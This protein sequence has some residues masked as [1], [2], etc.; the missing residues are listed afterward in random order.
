MHDTD[1]QAF[2]PESIKSRVFHWLLCLQHL[3]GGAT[4]A[5]LGDIF[6][7]FTNLRLYFQI[8]HLCGLRG[9]LVCRVKTSGP[10]SCDLDT[11]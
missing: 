1:K 2:V 10:G 7:K 3:S 4:Y 5:V 6:F 9:Y 8:R 11:S